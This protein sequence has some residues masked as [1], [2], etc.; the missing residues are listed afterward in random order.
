M[1]VRYKKTLNNQVERYTGFIF[2]SS[3]KFRILPKDNMALNAVLTCSCIYTCIPVNIPFKTP[4]H[5]GIFYREY[6]TSWEESILSFLYHF[7]N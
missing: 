3:C 5:T 4:G 1:K 2:C 6:P 7:I